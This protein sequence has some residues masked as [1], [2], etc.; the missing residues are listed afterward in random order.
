MPENVHS[1]HLSPLLGRHRTSTVNR[2]EPRSSRPMQWRSAQSAL[3]SYGPTLYDEYLGAAGY[4]DRIS[5]G[6]KPAELTVQVPTRYELVINL[7]TE[8][9]QPCSAAVIGYPR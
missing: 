2:R 7:K 6:E 9:D 4:V 3:S 1:R 8:G 5:R